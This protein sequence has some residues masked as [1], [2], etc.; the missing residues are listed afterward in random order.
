MSQFIP[1]GWGYELIHHNSPE[2]CC[3]TLHITKNKCL[4]Y[5]YHIKKK[6][7]FLI[8]EGE[9]QLLH[10]IVPI[11]HET[12]LLEFEFHLSEKT[13]AVAI[14]NTYLAYQSKW[15]SMACRANHT[16]LITLRKGDT[17][18]VERGILHA[19]RSNITADIIECSTEDFPEDSYRLVKG[20]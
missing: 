3:K 20:D 1:K 2:Y 9:V 7:T 16:K 8:A 4:S 12:K 18:T 6:E 19:L 14:A 10:S 5:H 15:E 13:P 11:N 17:F